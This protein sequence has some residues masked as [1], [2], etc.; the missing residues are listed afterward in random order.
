[1]FLAKVSAAEGALKPRVRF[2]FFNPAQTGIVALIH[3]RLVLRVRQQ[4][5]VFHLASLS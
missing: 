2:T 4:V 5:V 1:V 3:A